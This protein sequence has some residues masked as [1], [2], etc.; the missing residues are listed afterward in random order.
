VFVGRTFTAFDHYSIMV[1][2]RRGGEIAGVLGAA[3]GKSCGLSE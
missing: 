1:D 3:S 2:D